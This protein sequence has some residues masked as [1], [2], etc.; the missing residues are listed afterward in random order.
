[1]SAEAEVRALFKD[2]MALDAAGVSLVYT[3]D[4]IIVMRNGEHRGREEIRKSL[5][6]YKAATISMDIDAVHTS[7]GGDMATVRGRY[8]AKV[9]DGGAD[10]KGKFLTVLQKSGGKWAIH[11]D[12]SFAG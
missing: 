5:E 4:A 10:E 7:A 12:F 1:M 8:S 11:T 3:E 2:M 6:T 9:K